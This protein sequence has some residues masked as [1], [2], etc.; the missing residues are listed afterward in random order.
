MNYRNLI[1]DHEA[2]EA[3][4]FIV[5]TLVRPDVPRPRD[6]IKALHLLAHLLR[7][8]LAGEDV[9]IYHTVLAAQGGRHADT[10]A[11]MRDELDRLREDWEAYLYRW[12]ADRIV[13]E[14]TE[15][16]LQTGAILSRIRERVTFETMILYSLALHLDVVAIDCPTG[17]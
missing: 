2:I 4:A 17:D 1:A 5:V 6:A 11:R 9:V 7:D 16:A 12:G 10:A 15:F 3:A 8:H 14:W 13:G